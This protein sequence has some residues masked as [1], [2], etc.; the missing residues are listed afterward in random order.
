MKIHGRNIL[1]HH[2]FILVITAVLFPANATAQCPENLDFEM[3]NFF[4]WECDTGSVQI[5]GSQR[6]LTLNTSPPTINRHVM[7]SASPGDGLDF[8]G[9]FPVNCPNGS[10]HSIRL[11]NSLAKKG[12][13]RVYYTFTIPPGQNSFSLFYNYAIVLQD[14]GHL[15]EQQ[16]RLSIEVMNVTDNIK[17]TCASFDFV[18]NGGLPGF[19]VSA[20]TQDGIPVRY[21]DW[22]AASIKLENQAGKTFKISFT[23]MD[24]LLG[25]HFGYA[26][27]DFN[28]GCSTTLLGTVFCP[29]DPKVDLTAPPGFQ[30][31]RWFDNAN[32]TLGTEQTISFN[33]PPHAGAV[34]YV[35]LIPY[36]G[37]G[38]EQVLTAYLWDTLSVVANAGPDR[39]Y[40]VNGIQ[41]GEP[42]KAGIN[43]SWTPA[44]GLS[45]PGISNPIATPSLTNTRYTLTATSA[46]GG[47]QS[48]DEINLVKKCT[49]IEVYVPGAFTPDGN[50]TNDR[51]RPVTYGFAKLNYFRVYNRFG[52]LVY[53][54]NNDMPGWDGTIKGKPAAT[55]TVVWML[56]GVDAYGRIEKRQG[57]SVLIR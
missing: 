21:K 34:V 49:V 13:E 41:L 47:C 25:D 33:P 22:S 48:T 1:F 16:P 30:S 38:C 46:G 8:Y 12:A 51:L 50:G 18:V 37:Y 10:G 56:E 45:D 57:T 39:E 36:D 42:P 43:Y 2:V 3:G 35:Q 55:Q 11:G 40:C 9:N 27:I 26:Y 52:Q 7:Q 53:S 5:I 29:A 32:T 6:V 31:Y 4:N 23:T 54:A 20:R 28:S 44:A 24:C 17:D 14:P 19:L 15:P